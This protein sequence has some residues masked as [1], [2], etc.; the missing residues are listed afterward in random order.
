MKLTVNVVMSK[1]YIIF[2]HSNVVHTLKI[3]IM[4]NVIEISSRKFRENQREFFDLVDN[5]IRLIVRRGENKAYVVFPIDMK[6]LYLSPIMEKR[7]EQAMQ[8]IKDGKGEEYTA[9]EIDKLLG[10]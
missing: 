2:A 10:V 5:G 8:S 1:K 9:E 6:E 7:I 4:Q 3:I